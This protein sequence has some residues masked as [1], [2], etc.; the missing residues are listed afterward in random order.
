CLRRRQH[1]QCHCKSLCPRGCQSVFDRPDICQ[2]ERCSRGY[3]F[4]RCI[5]RNSRARCIGRTGSR[6]THERDDKKSR[7]DR[8]LEGLC[9]SLSVECGQKGVRS[10]CLLT[11]GIPETSLLEEVWQIQGK[12]HGITFE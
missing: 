2:V 10:V 6:K 12:A 9:R 7:K 4:Q 1:R 5:H 3:I 8:Y 11:T